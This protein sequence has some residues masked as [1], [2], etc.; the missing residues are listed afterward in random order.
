M[1]A[2]VGYA[3]LRLASGIAMLLA[4]RYLLGIST[5]E[6]DMATV[7]RVFAVPSP[8]VAVSVNWARLRRIR[9]RVELGDI[10]GESDGDEQ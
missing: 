7:R 8:A 5:P 1:L 2:E 6:R 3:L 10:G 9:A 4:S